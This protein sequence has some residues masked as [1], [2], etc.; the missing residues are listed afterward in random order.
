MKS[1]AEI[2]RSRRLWHRR[3]GLQGGA[4]SLARKA[5]RRGLPRPF[6]IAC[7]EAGADDWVRA[8]VRQLCRRHLASDPTTPLAA[9]NS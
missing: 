1:P 5:A 4:L 3:P 6:Q 8:P 7:L 2:V 9:G